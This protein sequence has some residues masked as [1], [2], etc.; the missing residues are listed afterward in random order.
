MRRG[1]ADGFV[2][3]Q[4][5]IDGVLPTIEAQVKENATDS[6][7]YEPFETMTAKLSSDEQKRLRREAEAVI[8]KAVMPAFA[9]VAQY[10][11]DEYQASEFIE[12]TQLPNGDEFYEFQIRKYTTLTN[13]TADDIHATG[14]AEVERIRGEMEAIIEELEFDGDF[15]EFFRILAHRSTILCEG[16]RTN[17]CRKS[18]L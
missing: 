17:C 9:K 4:I 13:S 16:L 10:L 7:F 5:V 18:P 6:S 2:L 3:P 1:S 8:V 15:D 14:L 12:A 11:A